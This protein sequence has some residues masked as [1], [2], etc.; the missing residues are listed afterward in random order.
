M[1]RKYLTY[2]LLLV[3]LSSCA[4]EKYE[5]DPSRREP[6]GFIVASVW[7]STNMVNEDIKNLKEDQNCQSSFQILKNEYAFMI[8]HCE[9][10][11]V[12]AVSKLDIPSNLEY[13]RIIVND[14]TDKSTLSVFP[15]TAILLHGWMIWFNKNNNMCHMTTTRPVNVSVYIL[16]DPMTD[17]SNKTMEEYQKESYMDS[18]LN[19]INMK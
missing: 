19:I 15:G 6:V 10:T 2:L 1:K 4:V 14:T 13:V 12:V 8:T 11:V 17:N 3:M 18:L 5:L 16:G 7:N 9:D